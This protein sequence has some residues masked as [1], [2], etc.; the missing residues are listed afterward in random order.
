MELR[1]RIASLQQEAC[2]RDGEEQEI[3]RLARQVEGKERVL[4]KISEEAAPMKRRVSEGGAGG[5]P[6]GSIA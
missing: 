2:A 6:A 5:M 4:A 1:H 3:A